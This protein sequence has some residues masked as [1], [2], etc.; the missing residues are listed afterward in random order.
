MLKRYA[1]LLTLSQG[2]DPA[3]ASQY[4]S[5]Q[6]PHPILNLLRGKIAM[7]PKPNGELEVS[8]IGEPLPR[9]YLVS[10]Y[11]GLKRRPRQGTRPWARRLISPIPRGLEQEPTPNRKGAEAKSEIRMA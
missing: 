8:P 1:Q 6:K 3:Q 2:I 5:F 10:R 9:F 4:L 7:V 11:E